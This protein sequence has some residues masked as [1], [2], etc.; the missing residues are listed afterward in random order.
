MAF[1]YDLNT[2]IGKVRFNIGDTVDA[3]HLLEDD[4]ITYILT[5]YPNINNASAYCAE[6]IAAQYAGKVDE[7]LG[8]HSKSYSQLQEHYKTMA[9]RL[10]A[11]SAMGVS[12][13]VGGA[14]TTAVFTEDKP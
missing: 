10:R 3:G 14:D 8:D 7:S 11:R 12:P 5:D 6:Q 9:I 4:E 13:Y 1:T 2:S